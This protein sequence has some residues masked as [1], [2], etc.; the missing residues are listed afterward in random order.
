[1]LDVLVV[2]DS[3][4]ARRLLVHLIES[5]P[6]LRL[7]GEAADGA[8]AIALAE[9][10]RPHVITMDIRMPN[11]DGLEATRRIMERVPSPIVVVSAAL[12]HDQALS[13]R[14]LEA[15]AL[16]V[17]AKPGGPGVGAQAAELVR[18]VKTMAGVKV[19]QRRPRREPVGGDGIDEQRPVGDALP[20]ERVDVVAVAASTGGPAALGTIVSGLPPELPVPVLVVQHIS[21]GFEAGLASWLDGL[22]PLRVGMAESG[23]PLRAGELLLA[24]SHH[25][26]GVS[27]AGRV[28]LSSAEPVGGHRPAATWLFQS[29]AAAYGQHA[30]G[31][32]LTGMGQDGADG[33][34]ALSSAGSCVV[35]QDEAS[36]LVASMPSAAVRRG[37]VDHVI[38][39]ETIS[40]LI[41]TFVAHGRS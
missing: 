13:F 22:T 36:S 1:M 39:L 32:V 9:R 11:V 18:T 30:L 37:V 4:T 34:V 2:D 28:V 17:L 3:P 19:I 15:G 21:P 38:P 14:A 7:A 41:E 16:A 25:H 31:L 12:P 23:R 5:D 29:V 24:P 35:A 8:Q 27:P 40:G 26:L 10:L 33:L 6:E 20:R